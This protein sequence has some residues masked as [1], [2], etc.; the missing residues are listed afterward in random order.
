MAS[1]GSPAPPETLASRVSSAH[2]T[3][4][5]KVPSVVT[6]DSLALPVQMGLLS[7]YVALP[8]VPVSFTLSAADTEWQT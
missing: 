8:W 6:L 3:F 5:L 2:H 4:P 7:T 1:A